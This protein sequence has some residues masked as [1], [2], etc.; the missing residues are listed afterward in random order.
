ME[1]NLSKK[2][3]KMLGVNITET[4]TVMSGKSWEDKLQAGVFLGSRG[5][6]GSLLSWSG[7]CHLGI[8]HT[9]LVTRE[10]RESYHIQDHCISL[11]D[12]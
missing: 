4:I 12:T 7:P 3:D 1:R 9:H 5:S 2:G 10:D 6:T 8:T 11:I